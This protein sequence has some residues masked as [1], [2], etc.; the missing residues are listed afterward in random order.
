MCFTTQ[1]LT[2]W[3]YWK[4]LAKYNPIKLE[5][6]IENAT[7]QKF[8]RNDKILN[9]YK[10]LNPDFADQIKGDD[11]VDEKGVY[12]IYNKW[13]G[14]TDTG[15]IG[16]LIQLNNSLSAEIDIAAQATVSRTDLVY[17]EPITNMITLCGDGS[18]YGN[19][20]R[21]SDPTVRST[22]GLGKCDQLTII[23]RSVQQ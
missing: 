8:E 16:H 18:S 2:N 21:N 10:E 1:T 14:Y 11:L 20:S 5:T 17:G 22:P 15:T 23:D 12:D 13:N 19:V 7:P 6:P 4:E 3:Q 9:I